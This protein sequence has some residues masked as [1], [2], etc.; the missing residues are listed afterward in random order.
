MAKKRR[1]KVV[2]LSLKSFAVK[3]DLMEPEIEGEEEELKESTSLEIDIRDSFSLACEQLIYSC[4][5]QLRAGNRKEYDFQII[6]GTRILMDLLFHLVASPGEY[7]TKETVFELIG[8]RL[9]FIANAAAEIGP[10]A[11]D[12]LNSLFIDKYSLSLKLLLREFENSKIQ[13]EGSEE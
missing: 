9:P 4:I 11:M 10:C 1:K 7:A 2:D 5:L 13:S 3:E 6:E 8:P 12:A